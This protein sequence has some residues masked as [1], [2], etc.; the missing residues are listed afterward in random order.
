MNFI[1]ISILLVFTIV[2]SNFL[3]C[4]CN[5]TTLELLRAI[6]ISKSNHFL[7]YF[8]ILYQQFKSYNF[9]PCFSG[10]EVLNRPCRSIRASLSAQCC[11]SEYM[12]SQWASARPGGLSCSSPHIAS[13][14]Q[15]IQ[16]DCWALVCPPAPLL[17]S[18][19]N[20]LFSYFLFLLVE[21]FREKIF[22]LFPIMKNKS[23]FCV[24]FLL[25]SCM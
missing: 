25:W 20:H 17:F 3:L 21:F 24:L 6:F 14:T 16:G 2:V 1:Q 19:F 15:G 13:C 18:T 5:G 7:Y 22:A 12:A 23:S 8:I 11:P 10:S 9:F 4:E